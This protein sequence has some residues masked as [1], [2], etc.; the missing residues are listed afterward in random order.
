MTV[1]APPADSID[2]VLDC[3]QRVASS[4]LFIRGWLC[5]PQD[6]PAPAITLVRDGAPQ[7]SLL[8]STHER[9][10]IIGLPPGSPEPLGFFLVAQVAEARS[11]ATLA[12]ALHGAGAAA[13]VALPPTPFGPAVADL[14]AAAPWGV[15]HDLLDAVAGD[16]RLAC[17][18]QADRQALGVFARWYDRL[19]VLAPGAEDQHGLRRIDAMAAPSGE[20][21]V[22][23][24]LPDPLPEDT[25]LRVVALLP[26][27]DGTTLHRLHGPGALHGESLLAL[28][29]R[30]PA[31]VALPAPAPAL[32]VELRRPGGNAWFRTQPDTLDAP[33]FLAAL[34]ALAGSAAAGD[35]MYGFTWLRGVLEDRAAAFAAM[36][37][38]AVRA[39]APD[40]PLVAVLHGV[41]DPFAARLAL[42]AAVPIERHAAE[43]LVVGPRAAAGAVADVFLERGRIPART[44][45]DLAA[46]VRRGT[47]A[48]CVLVLIDIA[49]LGEALLAGGAGVDALFGGRRDGARVA[50]HDNGAPAARHD[51]GAPPARHDNRAPPARHDNRAPPARHIDGATLPALLRLAV[52]AGT[53]DGAQTLGRLALLLDAGAG[54][55]RF[56]PVRGAFGQVLGDHLA[57]FWHDAAPCF[58]AEDAHAPA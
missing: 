42:L 47:Y 40:A 56:G 7:P 43:V 18:V 50:T 4:H 49:A 41:D 9:P 19:P 28:Y 55:L 27:A 22:A 54:A 1:P 26:G 46:A 36:A 15:V 8:F 21:A 14:L 16:P 34:G 2:L 48:R 44:S 5:W 13:S 29:G 17:L 3:V 6:R 38:P 32:V 33:G 45:L 11:G 37:R 35:A 52:V 53:M 39:A 10:D 58:L 25:A 20:C 12:V 30:M 51:S 31:E 23:V 57:G 24:T